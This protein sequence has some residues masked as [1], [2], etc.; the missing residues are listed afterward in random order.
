MQTTRPVPAFPANAAATLA[1]PA[2]SATTCAR[3]TRVRTAAAT[4]ARLD[5]SD[6]SITLWTNGPHRLENGATADAVH[7]AWYVL[8]RR[9]AA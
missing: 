8:D 2:P 1:A 7:K 4:S 5:T 3:V 6:A 9:W